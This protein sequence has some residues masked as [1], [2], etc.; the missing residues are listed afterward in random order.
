MKSERNKKLYYHDGRILLQSYIHKTKE[1]F[2]TLTTN[3]E[4]Y[5]D[6]LDKNDIILDCN[7]VPGIDKLLIKEGLIG[8]CLGRLQ[9]GYCTYPVHKW[10][11]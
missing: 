4:I 5:N 6:I 1:P 10:L 11:G 7:N 3:I 2:A 8:N 9:S